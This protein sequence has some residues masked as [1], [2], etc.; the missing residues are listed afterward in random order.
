MAKIRIIGGGLAGC[1]SAYQLLKRGYKVEM[2]E[3]RPVTLSPAHQ[4]SNLAELVCSNSLKSEIPETASGTLKEELKVL[5][6]GLLKAADKARVPAGSALAV[7]RELFSKEVE[8]L[9]FSYE[10][11]SLI[12]E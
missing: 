10:N 11:F 8:K 6:C 5:D 1:E 7:D 9:L 3:M 12:R 4:T 2:Y